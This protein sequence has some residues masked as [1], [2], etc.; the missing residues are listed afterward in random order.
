MSVARYLVQGVDVWL[1]TPLRPNEASGTSGMKAIVNGVLNLSILDGWWDEAYTD[2]K[3]NGPRIGWA[4]GS[5]E[6]NA[7]ADYQNDVDAGAIYD[8][9][10]RDV[11]PTFY[12]RK[13]DGLPYR[14]ISMMK[15]SIGNLCRSFNTH[16]MV[17]E[18]TE[19]FYLNA[20]EQHRKM[21]SDSGARAASL[22]DAICRIRK[23]WPEVD[24][25]IP[26]SEVP[27]EV[28]SGKAVHFQ[29]MVKTGSLSREDICVEL[30]TGLLNADIGICD[31]IIVPLTPAGKKGDWHI[32]EAMVTPSCNSGRHGYTVRVLPYNKDLVNKFLPNLIC[33]AK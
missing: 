21:T 3:S 18:Y 29:A 11:I 9:L 28:Q 26:D 16:R 15:S 30:C 14:W 6:P 20:D 23:A 4:I 24:V 5:G 1:N 7:D 33:W 32:Y 19:R 13:S 27:R 31:P 25:K 10:E 8:I 22:A 12:D 2:Y 17:R